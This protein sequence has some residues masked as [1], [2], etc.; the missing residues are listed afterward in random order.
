MHDLGRPL[1]YT[2]SRA[3]I[4]R[5]ICLSSLQI[6]WVERFNRSLLQM[7]RCYINRDQT[8]WDEQL[9]L[10][11]A[12]YRSTPHQSTGISPNFIMLGRKVHQITDLVLKD[13]EAIRE[14]LDHATY[15]EK[16][17]S[18]L[19]TAHSVA[20][21]SLYKCQQKQKRLHD[22]RL[23][24]N[25]YEIWFVNKMAKKV[26]KCPKLERVWEGPLL[27]LRNMVLCCMK[28][29]GGK[30]LLLFTMTD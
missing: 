5:A 19:D 27:L 12:A 6:V 22:V 21:K 20:R 9:L 8:V 23:F 1:R 18:A 14:A 4:F 24:N 29:K 26:G 28:F 2:K 3:G 7:I 11:L 15:T 17:K 13:S 30:P 25:Q 10:L 16:L